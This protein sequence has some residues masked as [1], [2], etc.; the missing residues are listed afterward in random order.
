M[1]Y[2][3]QKIR[4][5]LIALVFAASLSAQQLTFSVRHER[6]LR[7]HT[8]QLTFTASGVSFTQTNAKRPD[9]YTWP[10]EDIQQLTVSPGKVLVVTYQDRPWLAGVDREFE[11]YAA[12]GEPFAAVYDLL[13]NKLDRRFTAAVA[14][15][16]AAP[17]WEVPVRLTGPLRGSNGTLAATATHVVYKTERHGHS[18]TWRMEDID[19]IAQSDPW[20]LTLTTHERSLTHYGSRKAFHFQLK[21][22]LAE[23]HFDTLWKR[24]NQAQGLDLL[25]AF[26]NKERQ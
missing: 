24:L 12:S 3:S 21:K 19:N 22:P 16:L 14:E 10:Y 5:G 17:L 26:D 18:R 4:Y 20:T 2:R 7:D 15:P 23:K 25:T 9:A 8:G 11:F 6:M 1:E 13:K